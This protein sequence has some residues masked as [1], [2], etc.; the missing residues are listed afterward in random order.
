MQMELLRGRTFPST[1]PLLSTV[2]S[3][4]FVLVGWNL[5][6]SRVNR[7]LTLGQGEIITVYAMLAVATAFIGTDVGQTLAY[8]MCISYWYATPENEWNELISAHLPK[9]LSVPDTSVVGGLFLGQDTLYTWKHIRAWLAPTLWWMV[10]ALAVMWVMICLNVIVRRRWSEHE[11]LAYPIIELPFALTRGDGVRSVFRRRSLWVGFALAGGIDIWNGLNFLFPQ[12]PF[13]NVKGFD[14]GAFFTERPWNAIG[15]MPLTFYPFAFGIGFLMP[16]E[17]LFS[18][19]FFYLFW[20]LERVFGA[21]V[22][23]STIPGY[24]F[25]PEQIAGVWMALLAF[26]LRSGR[27]EFAAILRSAVRKSDDPDDAQ[28]PLSY[29]TATYGVVVG[30]GI[31]LAFC[32]RAGAELWAALAYFAIYFAIS[33]TIARIRAELGPPDHNLRDAGPDSILVNFLGSRRFSKGSLTTFSMFFWLNGEAYRNHPMPHALEGFKMAERARMNPRP[34]VLA[35]MV[36]TGVSVVAAMWGV[37]HYGYALGSTGFWGPAATYFPFASYRRLAGWATN[38]TEPN[39][40][41]IVVTTGTFVATFSA[42][43]LRA[44]VLWWHIHP[45]GLAISHAWG[46]NWFWFPLFLTWCVKRLVLRHGGV[47]AYRESLPFFFGLILG[48]YAVGSF[49]SLLGMALGRQLYAFWV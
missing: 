40:T 39:F 7:R 18:C 23:W 28:E 30:T 9:W 8:L 25:Q 20:R 32:Y 35:L 47:R 26:V 27:R 44:Q 43:L 15:W 5:L 21:V 42:L 49:W 13:L 48:E 31:A 24:P 36:A 34:L 33:L 4:V 16:L 3:T 1:L 19:W 12:I 29:R 22:G 14:V 38:P 10:F 6:A 17:L 46:M 45:I 2:V 11:R 41:A 37:L